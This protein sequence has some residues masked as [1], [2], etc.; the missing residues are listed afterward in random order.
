MGDS[1]QQAAGSN[2]SFGVA[3][4]ALVLFVFGTVLGEHLAESYGYKLVTR[5]D[6]LLANVAWFVAGIALS[7]IVWAT[8]WTTL[9]AFTFGMIAGGMAGFKI[10]F[11]ESIGPWKFVDKFFNTNKRHVA[12]AQDTHADARRKA[13]R[14]WKEGKGPEPELMSVQQPTHTN[15]HDAQASKKG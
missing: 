4:V 15:T 5:R 8:G 7:G 12:A 9:A 1:L 10:A 11:G 14:E 13:R 3:I 6:Y 2:I